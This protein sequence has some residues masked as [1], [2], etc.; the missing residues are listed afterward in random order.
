MGEKGWRGGEELRAIVMGEEKRQG[1]G[2][3]VVSVRSQV[4][5]EGEGRQVVR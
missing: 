3:G 5:G 2:W 1:G 4:K